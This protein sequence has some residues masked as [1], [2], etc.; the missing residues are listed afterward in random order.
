MSRPA[1][2][3]PLDGRRGECE[4]VPLR[5]LAQFAVKA[6]HDGRGLL[7]RT[8]PL[9]PFLET[10]E[11]EAAVGV[12][13]IAQEV[14]ADDRGTV[15]NAGGVQDNP[16]R[17]A[18]GLGGALERCGIGQLNDGVKVA[19]VLLGQKTAGTRLPSKPI[20]R[21]ATRRMANPITALRMTMPDKLT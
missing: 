11:E 12:P 6:G 15:L 14:E 5:Q 13:H 10:D 3:D 4:G 17:L 7:L 18:G 9:V 20:P 16:L 19:L 8:F 2:A 21:A 1:G